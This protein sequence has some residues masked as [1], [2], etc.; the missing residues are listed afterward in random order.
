MENK[1]LITVKQLP[2]IE[3][4]LRSVKA[5]F[6]DA[7]SEALA[8]ECTEDTLKAVRKTRAALKKIFA[9]L[10]AKRKEAKQEILAPYA[11]FEAVYREC[12]TDIYGSCDEQLAARIH[13]V[14]DELKA[15]KEAEIREYFNE[16]AAAAGVDFV[17]FERLGLNVTMAASKKSLRDAVKNSLDRIAADLESIY[18]SDHVDELLV[19]YKKSLSLADAMLTVK[20]RHDALAE[21]QERIERRRFLEHVKAQA[22]TKVAEAVEEFA[23]PVEVEPEPA[24]APEKKI[25]KCTFTVRATREELIAL[26]DFLNNGGYDYVS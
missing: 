4:R 7:V 10:E 24:P 25:L 8:L 11:A 23:A 21:E 2:V 26:R 19:E 17:P 9:S 14:E 6:E 18:A 12:V 3:E 5:Q 22:E 16:Y 1:E 15:E 20:R 13:G